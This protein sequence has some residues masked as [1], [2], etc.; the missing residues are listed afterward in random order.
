MLRTAIEEAFAIQAGHCTRM[1]SPFTAQLCR[2]VPRLLDESTATGRAVRDWALD[3]VDSALA[4]RVCGALHRLVRLGTVPDLARCYPPE[5]DLGEALDG[6]LVGAIAAQDE[7]LLA[8]LATPPQTNEIGRAGAL[9]GA[10]MRVSRETGLPLSLWEIGA[11]AGLNLHLDAYA[12]DFGAQSYRPE[13]APLT[14]ACAWR[15][16]APE[17]VPVHV[18]ARRACDAAPR[19]PGDAHDRETLLAFVWADQEARMARTMAALTHA[20]STGVVPEQ[21][22]AAEWVEARL[23]EAAEPGVARVLMHSIMWQYLD[24]TRQARIE[25]AMARAGETAT[26]E[27]PLAWARLERDATPGSAAL[28]LTCWPGATTRVLARADFHGAWVEWL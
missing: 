12:Y 28:L 3:P 24:A 14:V 13:G 17:I 2:R 26:R 19:N 23:A 27:T 6:A 10:L 4:L 16:A 1:G 11:S 22:D 8:L 9:I 15:G 18:T 21:A 20:A 5:A 25:T 7:A